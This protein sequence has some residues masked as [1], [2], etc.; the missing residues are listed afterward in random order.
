MQAKQQ[1]LTAVMKLLQAN[2]IG[3]IEI[4]TMTLTEKIKDLSYSL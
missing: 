1:R 4:Y 3:I 2:A